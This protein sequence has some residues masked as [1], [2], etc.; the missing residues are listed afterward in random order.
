MSPG[1]AL[2]AIRGLAGANRIVVTLHAQERMRRRG[3][4]YADLRC[5]LVRGVTCRPD[6]EKW[7]VTGPDTD[8]DDLTCVVTID[9]GVVV[10]TVF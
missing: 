10:V 8:G 7:K 9:S 4:L 2:E 6:D 3:V 1:E 5:A